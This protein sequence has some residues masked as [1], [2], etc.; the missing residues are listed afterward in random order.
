MTKVFE[1]TS[2]TKKVSS[3]RPKSLLTSIPASIRDFLELEDKTTLQ[4]V[5]EVDE[6]GKKIVKI[7][8]KE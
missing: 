7:T 1:K 6:D 8:K 3:R 2:K 5:A 4:W